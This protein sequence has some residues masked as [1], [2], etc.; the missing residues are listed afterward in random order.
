MKNLLALLLA[1]IFAV[2]I[3]AAQNAASPQL[4]MN[5]NP[6]T[7][8]FVTSDINLFW[9][10]YDAAKPENNINVFRDQYLRKGSAGLEEFRKLRLG[11][12]CA[13]VDA[14]EKAPKYYAALRE[15]SLKI[16][17]FE[18][19][20]RANFRRLREIY[21]AAVFPDV[22]FLIGRM[23]S[24]GTLNKKGLFIG[25][26]MFGK[27][28]GAPLDELGSWHRA[29][30]MPT[31]RIPLVVVHE[32]IHYQQKFPEDEE[33]SLLGKALSE[34]GADFVGEL[35]TGGNSNLQLHE[36]GNRREKELWL[37]FQKEMAGKDAANWL[38]QGDDVK[39]KPADLGYYVGY[40]ICEAYYKNAAD[41]K[42]AVRDILEIKDFNVFLKA[43]R[44][45]EKFKAK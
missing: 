1:V 21:P 30:I 44:Y 38:Y 3:V 39:D 37:E 29:A 36:Y 25:A 26:D 18:N 8:K 7:V 27:N 20:M 45:E 2:Q 24:A 5:Q 19:Q 9:K 17:S 16:A 23:S 15:P 12:A 34:G 4:T 31:A 35:I 33:W 32:S 10:A 11:S 41:K 6:E 42:Q 22:Y 28:E 13:L 43:S 40:K 14:I